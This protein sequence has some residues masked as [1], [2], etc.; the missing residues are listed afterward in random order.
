MNIVHLLSKH[1]KKLMGFAI[2]YIFIV[3][4]W[5]AISPN[6]SLYKIERVFTIGGNSGV[7]IFFMLSGFGL[8]YSLKNNS[9]LRFYFNRIKRIALPF[10]IVIIAFALY[11][12]WG[13]VE[14]IFNLFGINYFINKF[15]LYFWFVPAICLLYLLFPLYFVLF[16]KVKSKGWGTIVSISVCVLVSV[17]LSGFIAEWN[18]YL[19][20]LI[21]R[22]PL[23]LLGVYL[24]YLDKTKEIVISKKFIL[25]SLFFLILGYVL[26]YLIVFEDINLF[27]AYSASMKN[28][29]HSIAVTFFATS[30]IGVSFTFLLSVFFEWLSKLTNKLSFGIGKAFGFFGGMSFEFYCAHDFINLTLSNYF[31]G[32]MNRSLVFVV[33]F[34]ISTIASFGVYQLNKTFIKLLD[35][36]YQKLAEK[37]QQKKQSDKI[38]TE[39]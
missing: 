19:L 39:E 15:N 34:I 8:Y 11:S 22:I 28:I 4:C 13:V 33:F 18:A 10:L 38:E 30:I 12:K 24:G 17:F 3:H 37:N 7:D 27:V 31:Y 9:I 14:F 25:F 20:S 6:P 21:N 2:L 1:R 23:F 26:V 36:G 32:I 16:D 29:S 5:K 35:K